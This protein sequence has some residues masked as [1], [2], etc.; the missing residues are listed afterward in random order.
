LLQ[1]SITFS[2]LLLLLLQNQALFAL[3]N[4]VMMLWLFRGFVFG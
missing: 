2:H 1:F 3:V 4:R